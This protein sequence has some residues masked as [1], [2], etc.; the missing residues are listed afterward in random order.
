M[1]I[2]GFNLLCA[3]LLAAS[4]LP[5]TAVARDASAASGA[6]WIWVDAP[7]APVNTHAQ[8]KTVFVPRAGKTELD[9]SVAG[10]Y[11]A[12]VN[13]RFAAFGQYTDYPW[14]K[15]YS[16][17]DITRFVRL[18][19]ENELVVWARHSGDEF[20]SHAD[21]APGLWARVVSA[22]ESVAESGPSWL[23]RVDT[24]FAQ[25]AREKLFV[26][27][28]WTWLYDAR[29]ALPE[30]RLSR[31]SSR[32]V[33]H[34]GVVER[35]VSQ[36]EAGERFT[37]R[38]LPLSGR[39]VFD[40]GEETTGLV[41]F[42]VVARAGTTVDVC[43]AEYMVGD[44]LNPAAFERGKCFRDVFVCA[45]GTND[46]FYPLRRYGGRFFE[47]R[48]R[49]P[50]DRFDV[51]RFA[52][53]PVVADL[54]TPPCASSD[55]LVRAAHDLAVRTLRLC[56]HERYENCPWRE[57]SICAFDARNQMLF[58]YG[59]WGNYDRAA[60]M[61]DLFAQGVKSN[62][63][64]RAAAPTLKDLWIPSFTF[65][66]M[67]AIDEHAVYSG[68]GALFRRHAAL[69]EEMLGKI[70]ASGDGSLFFPP[71]DPGRWDYGECATLEFAVH[72]PNAFYNL[73]LREA[74]L[75][76]SPRFRAL[77]KVAFAAR[78][79]AA[80]ASIGDALNHRLYDPV[81]GAYADHLDPSGRRAGYYAFVQALALAQGLVPDDGPRTILDGLKSGRW[82]EVSLSNMPYLA[83]AV[84]AHGNSSDLRWL[85]EKVRAFVRRHLDAG[86]TT[87]WEDAS[88][89]AYAGGGGSLC[90]GWSAFFPWYESE[91]RLWY[92]IGTIEA[93]DECHAGWESNE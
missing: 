13:G 33:E 63:F 92:N 32:P 35:P 50:T 68:S 60:A 79:D 71:D 30:W 83:R 18:G 75:R 25:G 20:T 61:I 2:R 38:R 90:H 65:A 21:G 24:R 53:R 80:A 47:L 10:N 88:G 78:L 73:Y 34:Q 11:A 57:Q 87:C 17:T 41:D 59:L 51:V 31:W 64:V 91:R 74:L 48:A 81:E 69:V 84:F 62:G 52:L 45:E 6:S 36:L 8:F 72:P 66:W 82:G 29:A 19:G 12:F 85:D 9:V 28:D 1:E 89:P 58:G 42:S 43:H 46:F 23:S 55:P 22:G 86:A 49:S 5:P 77:G 39:A 26:S 3:A 4:A 27:L 16:R 15:T 54:P 44:Q 7:T 76:L 93:H 14:R 40:A 67:D 56:Q 70:L 37:L